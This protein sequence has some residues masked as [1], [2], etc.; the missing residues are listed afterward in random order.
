MN[1]ERLQELLSVYRHRGAMPELPRRRSVKPW[2]I[3]AAAI[4]AIGVILFEMR[5]LMG[6]RVTEVA[7]SA[8]V[9]WL[10]RPG[11]VVTTGSASR[12]RLQSEEIGTV[13]IAEKT[14]LRVIGRHRLALVS[15]TIHAWTTSPPG[16]F[17]VDTPRARAID[18]GC[19]YVLSVGADGGGL[20]RVLT[21]WVS[22]D[23]YGESLVP[24]GARAAISSDGRLSAPI[25]EDAPLAFQQAVERYSFG[26]SGDLSTVLTLARQRDALT[27][28]NL[29][30]VATTEER[31][32]IY[33][34]LNDLVPAPPQVPR[35]ALHNWTIMTVDPWWPDVLKA[36]GVTSIKKKKRAP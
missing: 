30:R 19:E 31:F 2:L 29:F 36:S 18:L 32:R 4:L 33:D 17:V 12:V 21:G 23:A 15:G 14:S 8:R 7:G 13:D 22:L 25:F 20:L 1:E 28:I 16:L 3:A 35:D 9:P 24:Q 26:S 10:L 5:P 11:V 6:W 34:R 27:L